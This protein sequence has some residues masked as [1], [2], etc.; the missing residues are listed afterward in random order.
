MNE[1]IT[2]IILAG[3]RGS[4][5]GGID[6]GLLEFEG[7]PLVAHAINRIDAQVDQLIISANRNPE[8]YRSYGYPVVNDEFND[9]QGPLAGILAAGKSANTELLLTVPCDTPKLPSNLR[10]KLLSE[11]LK[12][13]AEIAIAHDG[14]RSQQLCM[15]LKTSL[16]DDMENYLKKGERRVIS[17]IKSHKWTEVDFSDAPKAFRNINK[18]I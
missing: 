18:L 8:I 11:L 4:R 15:L 12:H 5:M 1:K 16:L 7:K 9:F 6:K 3:G 14:Q 2:G 10:D 13:H 17:W